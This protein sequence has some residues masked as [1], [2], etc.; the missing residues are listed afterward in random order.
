MSREDELKKQGWMKRT[1]QS[2]PRLTELVDL[3]E[4]IGLE[5]H[6]EPFR[7]EDMDDCSECFRRACDQY[8][9]IYTRPVEEKKDL[10]DDLY[11]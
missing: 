11:K 1:V 6:L 7:P 8:K 2:E 9:V 10:D 3:Y 5:V 4:N